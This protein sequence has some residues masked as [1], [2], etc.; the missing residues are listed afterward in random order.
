MTNKSPPCVPILQRQ[1]QEPLTIIKSVH[2]LK[3]PQKPQIYWINISKN[4]TNNQKSLQWAFAYHW[5]LFG[6]IS[7][8]FGKIHSLNYIKFLFCIIESLPIRIFV[9][10]KYFKSYLLFFNITHK[11]LKVN[12]LT[13]KVLH[14]Q[15]RRLRR[16][17]TKMSSA[18]LFRCINFF[19]NDE[20]FVPV[21]AFLLTALQAKNFHG[22]NFFNAFRS[23]AYGLPR[24]SH[25]PKRHPYYSH[26]YLYVLL[27]ALSERG[28]LSK[29]LY[30]C[31]R[32]TIKERFL[33]LCDQ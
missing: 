26:L 32:R 11:K 17:F 14:N 2:A 23:F 9:V 27:C 10:N 24:W 18:L 16:R 25:A 8:I 3:L 1:H 22:Q 21:V 30:L 5:G 28:K 33:D 20:F 15:V 29:I 12:T 6:D 13:T 7:A 31:L 19:W 4:S